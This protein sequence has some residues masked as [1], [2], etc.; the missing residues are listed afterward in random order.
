MEI[1]MNKPFYNSSE[2]NFQL[3]IEAEKHIKEVIDEH[4]P[5]NLYTNQFEIITSEQMLDAYASHAMPV[6]YPHWSFGK[7]FLIENNKYVKGSGLAYELVINSNPCINYLLED[8]TMTMQLLVM[9]HAGFGHN[10]F[11]KNNY[12]FKE[13]TSADSIIEYLIFAKNFILKC[14]EKYGQKEVEKILDACHSLSFQGINKYKRPKKLNAIEEINRAKRKEDE[15]QKSYNE[16]WK[17]IPEN[18]NNKIITIKNS[19]VI[20]P[21]EENILYFIEKN[22]LV[23]KPWQKEIIRI[24]RKISEYFYPQIETKVMNEGFASYIHYLVLNKLW[25]KKL[26]SDGQFL[27][28]LN[29]HTAVVFQP[30]FAEFNP[31]H[32]GFN[33]FM[34]VERICTNP[35]KEDEIWF[36]NLVGK[37]HKKEILNIVENYKDESFILQFLSPNLIRK[38]KLFHIR[39]DKTDNFYHVLNIHDDLGYKNIRSILSKNYNSIRYSPDISVDSVNL[40]GDRILY[41]KHISYNNKELEK[42][43]ASKTLQH[44]KVL[45]GYDIV[46]STVDSTGKNIGRLSTS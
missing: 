10:H 35:T 8:N 45:W 23:L 40:K 39:T 16:L 19:D 9:A 6:M 31:Y 34:D 12:L 24:T 26:I 11:F 17:T 14:E 36:P 44:L 5:L 13:W 29:H 2:W 28:F 42:Q 46:L 37:D 7:K 27:E 38:L 3:L 20:Y 41:L 15:L 1:T 30:D 21:N 43:Y 4:F 32:L 33:I 25:E 22:S 18:K